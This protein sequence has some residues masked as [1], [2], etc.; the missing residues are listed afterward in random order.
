MKTRHRISGTVG[1]D[2]ANSRTR[3]TA[4][5]VTSPARTLACMAVVPNPDQ[6][7]VLTV[8]PPDEALRLARPLLSEDEMAIEG[9]TDDEWEAFEQALADR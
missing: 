7:E 4:L 5:S 8:V 9:L 2:S 1:T 3:R 6:P